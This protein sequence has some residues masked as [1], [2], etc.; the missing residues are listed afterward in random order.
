MIKV[1]FFFEEIE[2]IKLHKKV[3]KNAFD[4]IIKSEQKFPGE[5]SVIFCSD[6]Y[7]LKI[8]EQYLNHNYY[9]DIVTFNYVENSV[10]SGD[11]FISVHRVDENANQMGVNFDEELYRVMFHGMLHLCGYNDKTN[12]EKKVMREKEDFYLGKAGFRKEKK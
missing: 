7:L 3:V 1:S 5:I 4:F 8:N 11:L 10:I 2:P 12:A 9:T 6:N